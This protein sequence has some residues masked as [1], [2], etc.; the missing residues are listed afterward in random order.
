MEEKVMRSKNNIKNQGFTL[1]ELI[2]VIVILGIISGVAAPLFVS[3]SQEAKESAARGS[4]GAMRS[5]IHI[6]Y[7]KSALTTGG[8][9][10]FPA[11]ITTALFANAKLPTNPVN[12]LTTV[13]A[14]DGAAAA[15]GSTGWQY[16]SA[17]GVVR[18]NTTGNDS[19]GTAW[20]AY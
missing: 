3:M 14:W 17:T 7:G 2:V 9:P 20:T 6:S 5:A 16:N 1:I 11:A 13:A 12:T 15:D 8:S 10:V 19:A 4:L 18:L